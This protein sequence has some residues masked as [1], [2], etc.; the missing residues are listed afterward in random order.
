MREVVLVRCD[1][2]SERLMR[3]DYMDPDMVQIGHL[4]DAT[5]EQIAEWMDMQ[6]EGENYHEFVGVSAGLARVIE[7]HAG[8]E[9]ARAVLLE[10]VQGPGIRGL[11]Q[12]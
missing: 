11:A 6:A 4:G 9:V 12:L 8:P 5:T 7:R 1:D 10:I 2:G 3:R